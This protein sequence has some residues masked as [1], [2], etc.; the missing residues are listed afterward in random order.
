MSKVKS[1][2]E[3]KRLSLKLDRRNTYGESPHGSRKNIP[4]SKA[5]QHQ[6]ERRAASQTLSK[7]TDTSDETLL[8]T[9]DNEVRV[10][11]RKKRLAGFKKKPDEPLGKVI[12]QKQQRRQ[13][14]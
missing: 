2:T 4:K 1:P 12:A 10:K 9:V 5:I 13:R 8:E 3:K 11:T 7:G 14:G 6:Q